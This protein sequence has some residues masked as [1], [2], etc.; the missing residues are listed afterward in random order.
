[1]CH[2]T[3]AARPSLAHCLPL[4]FL[5]CSLLT[6][7]MT[8]EK[9]MTEEMDEEQ[10]YFAWVDDAFWTDRKRIKTLIELYELY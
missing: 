9:K 6:S 4:D 5:I 10:P 7:L 2:G 3:H 8:T 1:M